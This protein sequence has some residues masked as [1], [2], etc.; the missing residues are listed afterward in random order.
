MY[1]KQEI[2]K[3]GEDIATEYLK[4][5][6][7]EI[8]ERNFRTKRGE[9]DIIARDTEKD[10]IVIVEVKT[11]RTTEY[12]TPAEAVNRTKQRHIYSATCYYLYRKNWWNKSIRFDVIEVFLKN[13][14]YLI[15]HIKN[16]EIQN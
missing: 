5:L 11:R 2:G 10:E 1:Y 12:G 9:L 14:K 7:Y 4:K 3:R 16:I 6:K 13:E 8:L 15:N